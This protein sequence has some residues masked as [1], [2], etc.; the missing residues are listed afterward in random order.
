ME[1][2]TDKLVR[3]YIGLIIRSHL[4]HDLPHMDSNECVTCEMSD[5]YSD[6]IHK[7]APF[8]TEEYISKL[9]LEL[10]Q[11]ILDVMNDY[12]I[13]IKEFV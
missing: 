1:I 2:L 10:S 5:V 8:Y 13:P 7:Y 11:E 3:R 12:P 9:F 4:A 6:I